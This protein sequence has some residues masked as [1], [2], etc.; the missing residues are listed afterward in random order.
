MKT[1][2]FRAWDGKKMWQ[3]EDIKGDSLH[4][5]AEIYPERNEHLMQFTGL[6]DKNGK[7]I[8][9]GDIVDMWNNGLNSSIEF[10]KSGFYI[11][12]SGDGKN[13]AYMLHQRNK[14]VKIIGNIYENPELNKMAV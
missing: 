13:S 9:E 11:I 5:I 4:E 3:W 8:Y 10:R 1:I 7:E 2:K 6:L 12:S 14:W